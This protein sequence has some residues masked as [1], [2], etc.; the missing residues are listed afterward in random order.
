MR[1]FFADGFEGYGEF[2]EQK[3]KD[4]D[5]YGIFGERLA[6]SF[7]SKGAGRLRDLLLGEVEKLDFFHRL[8]LERYWFGLFVVVRGE[9][10]VCYEYGLKKGRK[11]VERVVFQFKESLKLAMYMV[12]S[13]EQPANPSKP[14]IHPRDR[15]RVIDLHVRYPFLPHELVLA[16][17]HQ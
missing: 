9:W 1:K 7:L 4:H 16:P 13:R 8:G 11:G 6:L 3:D 14:R 10:M 5:E 15:A 12:L 17:C 2:M